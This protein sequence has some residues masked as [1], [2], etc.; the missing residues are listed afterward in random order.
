M[1]ESASER[2]LHRAAGLPR[3]SVVV[4]HHG[5]PQP[6]LRLVTALL[7]QREVEL[8]VVVADDCSPEPFPDVPGVDVV[9]RA[10]NAGF[11]TNVNSG[12]AVAR[13]DLLLV[14]NSDVEVDDRFVADLVLAAAPWQPAVVSPRVVDRDGADAW[15]ARRFPT[16]GQQVVEWLHPLARYRHRLHNAVG[17]D[18]SARGR[19][20]VVDWVV[21][22]ALLIPMAS[23]REAGGFDERFFMNSE[24][25]DLQRRLRQLGVPSVVVAE[26]HL[27]HEGGG[28]SPSAQRRHWLVRSRLTYAR[29]WSGRSGERRLRTALAGASVVN[30]AWNAA[31]A[32][33]GRSTRPLGTFREELALLEKTR[34]DR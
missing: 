5:D 9:R 30:L 24:E 32:V 21:G 22:A 16:T 28:S 15:V 8:Q 2:R 19:T 7:R 23:F 26:P 13:H 14:L 18:A 1:S 3:V 4:P 11:G 17:H 27:V 31:R 33:A 25:V 29:K 10:T 12:A 6:T 34:P 20:A